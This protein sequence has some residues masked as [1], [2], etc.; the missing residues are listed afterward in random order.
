MVPTAGEK[1]G[2]DTIAAWPDLGI[3][4]FIGWFG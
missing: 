4:W 3:G 1:N 2:T